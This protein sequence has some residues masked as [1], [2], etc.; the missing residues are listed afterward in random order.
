MWIAETII[1]SIK[2]SET[3]KILESLSTSDNLTAAESSQIFLFLYDYTNSFK[4]ANTTPD[5]LRLAWIM[6]KSWIQHD[7]LIVDRTKQSFSQMKL[8]ADMIGWIQLYKDNTIAWTCV[9]REM[10][11]SR[12]VEAFDW[13]GFM[14]DILVTISDCV[15]WFLLVEINDREFRVLLWSKFNKNPLTE[16]KAKLWMAHSKDIVRWKTKDEIIGLI[17][18]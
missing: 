16:T 17:T 13:S 9:T 14:S 5:I 15:L 18:E 10:L 11:E 3:K 6:L 8:C 1:S 12:N 4:N 2:S 7:Q